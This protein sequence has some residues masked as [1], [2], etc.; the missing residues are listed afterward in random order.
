M[1]GFDRRAVIA[2]VSLG[3]V[4]ILGM[5]AIIAFGW[6][7]REPP[8]VLG[9]IVGGVITLIGYELGGHSK[10]PARNRT[11]SHDR[12]PTAPGR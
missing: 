3:T 6:Q 4:A 12:V 10:Q 11:V 5:G 2:L 8:Q 1:D 9:A 7:G